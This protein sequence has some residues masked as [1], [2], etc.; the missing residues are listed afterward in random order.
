MYWCRFISLRSHLLPFCFLFI[1]IY[2][3]TFLFYLSSSFW[4]KC[5]SR[6]SFFFWTFFY[7]F[8]FTFFFF[9]FF[10]LLQWDAFSCFWLSLNDWVYKENDKKWIITKCFFLLLLLL[11]L[12]PHTPSPLPFLFLSLSLSLYLFIYVCICQSWSFFLLRLLSF[13]F[14]FFDVVSSL[15]Y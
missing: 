12:H 14:S 6:F 9:T 13:S 15:K 4:R 2:I 8:L 10:L 11:L 7:F 1:H 3:H 5:T